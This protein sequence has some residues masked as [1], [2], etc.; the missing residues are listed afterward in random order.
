MANDRI[1]IV[2]R[3]CRDRGL[4]AKYYPPQ[5]IGHGVWNVARLEAFVE[6][7]MRCS[8]AF[9]QSTLEGDRCFDLI[10][11]SDQRLRGLDVGN[12]KL[13]LDMKE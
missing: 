3:H 10:A 13:V 4:L 12:S 8:P 7:H 2:C 9:G 5:T 11:E 6:Q 1:F